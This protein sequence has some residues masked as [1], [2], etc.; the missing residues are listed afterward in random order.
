MSVPN[1]RCILSGFREPQACLGHSGYGSSVFNGN[2]TP[3][4]LPG[5]RGVIGNDVGTIPFGEVVSGGRLSGILDL[6]ER[7]VWTSGKLDWDME[8]KE[9]WDTIDPIE[10]VLNY[11]KELNKRL[12]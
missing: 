11:M 4:D 6:A 10:D 8:D 2:S 12:V 9:N 5:V 7:N 1:F 3:G